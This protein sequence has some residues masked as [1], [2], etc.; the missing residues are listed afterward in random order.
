MFT[1]KYTKRMKRYVRRTIKR[2]K[3][4]SKLVVTLDLLATGR[5]MPEEYHDHPLKGYMQGYRECHL[6]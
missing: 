6:S 1:I 5:Q 2:R 4:I 3:N